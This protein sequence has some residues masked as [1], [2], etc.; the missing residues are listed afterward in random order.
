MTRANTAQDSL[1]N[2]D[3]DLTVIDRLLAGAALTAMI[4]LWLLALLPATLWAGLA[5]LAGWM[6]RDPVQAA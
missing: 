6:D 1:P 4:C 3:P 5:M 2:P